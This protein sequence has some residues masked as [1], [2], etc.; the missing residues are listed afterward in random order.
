MKGGQ[1]LSRF[2]SGNREA[3]A[4]NGHAFRYDGVVL[5]HDNDVCAPQGSGIENVN[6]VPRS[7]GPGWRMFFA[8]G[9]F[10]CYGWQVFSAV[11]VDERSWTKEPGV[12]LTNGG[13]LPP[14]APVYA[15]WPVGEGMVTEQLPSGEWRM[16]VGGYEQILPYEDKFQIVEW[17]S[18]DQLNW[19]YSGPVLTTRDMPVGGQGTIY[20]PTIREI[21]PGLWRMIFSGDDR[22]QPGWRGRIWSAVSTDKQAWQ[23][24]GELMGSPETKLWYASLVD[25]LLIFIR[26]DKGGQRRL[27]TATIVMP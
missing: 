20:S 26:E 25:D 17:R 15:P 1:A 16:M 27:A 10:T 4:R 24:E 22:K 9:S 11:S 14:A 23:M 7:D 21:A 8:A 12:R 19:S 5:Q 18:Q 6:I 2:S 13:T 3:F